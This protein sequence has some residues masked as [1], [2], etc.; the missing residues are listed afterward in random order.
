LRSRTGRA[1]G[2]AWQRP[3]GECTVPASG[4][5]S[6][7]RRAEES[8]HPPPGVHPM[9]ILRS[10]LAAVIVPLIAPALLAADADAY[11]VY[12]GTYTGG[13]SKGVYRSQLDARTGSLTK[14][15]LA[16][17]ATNPSFVWPHPSGKFLYAVAE[18][19]NL[20]KKEGG[21]V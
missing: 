15:E 3:S 6:S 4:A 13:K 2:G 18:V 1:R 16:A 9:R 14:P 17:A 19:E 5:L 8:P 12:F 7:P 21:V 20:A 11:W 10:L